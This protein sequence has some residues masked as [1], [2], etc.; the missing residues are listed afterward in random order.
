MQRGR[1]AGRN[2]ENGR[3]GKSIDILHLSKTT[4]TSVKK[5]TM[6]KVKVIQLIQLLYS[7][8]SNNVLVLKCTEVKT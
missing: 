2:S 3:S 6:V 8:I 7:S 4:D 1:D 5:N